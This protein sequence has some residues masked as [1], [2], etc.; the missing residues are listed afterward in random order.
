MCM[1][2][3]WYFLSMLHRTCENMYGGVRLGGLSMPNRW[4]TLCMPIYFNP[5]CIKRYSVPYIPHF[6]IRNVEGLLYRC[7]TTKMF[8]IIY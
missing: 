1:L 3:Q 7:F 5:W 4:F 8:C 6:C 2:R